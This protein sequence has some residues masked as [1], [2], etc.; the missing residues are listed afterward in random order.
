LNKDGKVNLTEQK[1]KVR[2]FLETGLTMVIIY[3]GV[4]NSYLN[5]TQKGDLVKTALCH[6]AR[7]EIPEAEER[8]KHSPVYVAKIGSMVWYFRVYNIFDITQDY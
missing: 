5:L 8:I 1:P 7:Q 6:A 4:K 2:A 3:I